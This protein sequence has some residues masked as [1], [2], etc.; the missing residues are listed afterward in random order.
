MLWAIRDRDSWVILL[1]NLHP[2]FV[3]LRKKLCKLLR[4]RASVSAVATYRTV[5]KISISVRDSPKAS[6][7]KPVSTRVQTAR[8]SLSDFDK[9]AS[10]TMLRKRRIAGTYFEL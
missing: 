1:N 2:A 7:R 9:R 8:P 5:R 6:S 3:G 4:A 10:T